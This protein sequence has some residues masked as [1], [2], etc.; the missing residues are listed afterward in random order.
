LRDANN[1][2]PRRLERG[3]FILRDAMDRDGT[4]IGSL[5]K[6]LRAADTMA[7]TAPTS[8]L[9]LNQDS[10]VMKCLRYLPGRP[11]IEE[12]PRLVYA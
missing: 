12:D 11:V 6:L 1:Q 5:P 4:K 7:R 3:V 9:V 2:N 8:V 10:E